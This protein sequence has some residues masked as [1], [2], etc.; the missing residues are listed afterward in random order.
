M[1]INRTME[2]CFVR[3]HLLSDTSIK[4]FVGSHTD[5]KMST[6]ADIEAAKIEVATQVLCLQ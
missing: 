6:L 3:C 5:Q 4:A 2:T 1:Y